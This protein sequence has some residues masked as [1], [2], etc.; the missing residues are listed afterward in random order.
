MSENRTPVGISVLS[1]WV[2]RSVQQVRF[3]QFLYYNRAPLCQNAD[4]CKYRKVK[5]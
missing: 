5:K 3:T 1:S 2:K 4:G